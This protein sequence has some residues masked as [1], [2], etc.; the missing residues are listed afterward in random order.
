MF[1]LRNVLQDLSPA[2]EVPLTDE[3]M[4]SIAPMLELTYGGKLR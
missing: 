4:A 2:T 3:D 1:V